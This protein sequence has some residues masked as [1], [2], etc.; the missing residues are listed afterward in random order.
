MAAITV[1]VVLAGVIFWGLSLRLEALPAIVLTLLLGTAAFTT[2][3]IGILRF[4]KNADTAP[5]IVNLFVLPLTFISNI[6]FPTNTLPSAL[7]SIASAFPI[8]PLASS[9][10]YAFDPRHHGAAFDWGS[11]RTL[12]IWAV[13][14]TFLM[15]RFLRRPLGDDVP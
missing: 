6:W 14:G 12:L 13:V 7:R 4:V 3:G 8:K 5:V 11:L 9:L 2:L 15:V 10:Q 1:V